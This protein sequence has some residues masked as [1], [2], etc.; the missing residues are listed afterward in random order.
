MAQRLGLGPKNFLDAESSPNSIRV[1]C[2]LG[3]SL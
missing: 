1:N 2:I 3:E